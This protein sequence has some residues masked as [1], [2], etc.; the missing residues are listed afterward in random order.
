MYFYKK[1]RYFELALISGMLGKRYK[2]GLGGS[3]PDSALHS[4]HE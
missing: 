4:N 1:I 2:C 3:L